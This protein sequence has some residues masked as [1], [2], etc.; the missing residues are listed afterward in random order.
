MATVSKKIF[1]E[2]KQQDETSRNIDSGAPVKMAKPQQLLDTGK[3]VIT[4][5]NAR[6]IEK[7][8]MFGKAN[9]Y[10]KLTLGQQKAYEHVPTEIIKKEK[11]GNYSD[12]QKADNQ[13]IR[14]QFQN[15]IFQHRN[16]L[17][18]DFKKGL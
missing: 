18:R 6:N 5:F 8:G 10:V 14:K 16:L 11:I 4:L 12:S 7:K 13:K 9:A 2:S 15:R 17:T 3:L 1:T